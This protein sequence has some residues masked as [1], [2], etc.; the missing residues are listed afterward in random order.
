MTSTPKPRRLLCACCGAVAGTWQQWHNQDTGY[1]LCASCADWIIERDLR[2]P[3]EWRTD[4][5]RT[6]GEPGVHR[7]AG[8][9]YEAA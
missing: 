8:P 2:K 6:Y 7:P 3:E 5:A 4:M 9:K 1:G